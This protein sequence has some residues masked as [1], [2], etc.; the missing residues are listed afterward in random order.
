MMIAI[1]TVIIGE[2]L[3]TAVLWFILEGGKDD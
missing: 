1:M 3:L 2:L